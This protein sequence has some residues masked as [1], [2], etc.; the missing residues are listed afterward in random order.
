L[1]FSDILCDL[2]S[3]QDYCNSEQVYEVELYETITIL[4]NWKSEA[5]LRR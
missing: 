1:K 4:S 2:T 3:Y 5:L